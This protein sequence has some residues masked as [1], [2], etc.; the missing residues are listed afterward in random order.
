M[1]MILLPRVR[2]RLKANDVKRPTEPRFGAMLLLTLFTL[3]LAER[4]DTVLLQSRSFQ[5]HAVSAEAWKRL[6]NKSAPAAIAVL[7]NPEQVS[8]AMK[9]HEEV[10]Q[11]QPERQ[12]PSCHADLRNSLPAARAWG[13]KRKVRMSCAS[14]IHHEIHVKSIESHVKSCKIHHLQPKSSMFSAPFA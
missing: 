13:A 14:K 5:Y 8:N 12:L 9:A 1:K 6:S 10:A 2:L 7:P 3:A 4:D 11:R